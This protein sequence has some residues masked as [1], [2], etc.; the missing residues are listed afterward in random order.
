MTR[1]THTTSP[2]KD[3]MVTFTSTTKTDMKPALL[4]LLLKLAEAALG[5]VCLAYCAWLWSF[6]ITYAHNH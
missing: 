2:L 5:I 4:K 1:V 3:G 6:T